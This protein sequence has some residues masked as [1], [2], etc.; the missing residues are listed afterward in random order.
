M[1]TARSHDQA[2]FFW[3]DYETSGTDPQKDRPLQFAGVRTDV[4]FN[5]IDAPLVLYCKPATDNLPDPDACLITGITPQLAEQKGVSEAEFIRR[6]HEQMAQPNT[7]T[8]GYNSLRFDDEVTRNCLYR[9]FYDPYTREWQNGNSRWDL[10]DVVRAARAFRPDGI[11][12]PV[13]EDG[14]PSFRLDQLT[15]INGIMHESAHDALADVHATI[16]IAKL[17]K[18]AQPKLYHFLFQHRVKTEAFNLLQLG[19]FKPVVHVSGKYPAAKHCLAIVLPI[20]KHPTNT[21][22]VIVYD[23][24]VDP[25]PMLTLSAEDI[26][27]RIF[28]ATADLP[29]GIDRIPLKTVHINKCP[30]LA[31]VSVIR[32]KD[33]QRLELDLARCQENI[34]K[35][36]AAMGLSDKLSVVFSGRIYSEP[37]TDPDLAIYSGGFFSDADKQKMARIRHISPEQLAKTAFNFI[38]PR[39]PEML[40]RYRARNYPETLNGD[41]MLR[42]KAFCINRLT[43]RQSGASITFESYFRRLQELRSNEDVSENIINALNDYAL[44]KMQF[45]G[46]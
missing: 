16:A 29:D 23:L 9:N 38:D 45:L 31:P 2:T 10:I 28:T 39:L 24:S 19:S 32:P 17:I 35:I 12:W 27:Q 37:E 33:E 26:Q 18:Q 11:Q 7:C 8:L 46:L 6:I 5:I 41:E 43:G 14:R 21:N 15:G 25:E 22:G 42:W 13:N 20:C 40:F 34:N 4:D 30:V 1:M 3:H 36:K 44:S